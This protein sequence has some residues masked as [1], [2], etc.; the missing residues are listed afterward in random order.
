M[1]KDFILQAMGQTR[2]RLI[3]SF[4]KIVDEKL[5]DAA[6]VGVIGCQ[7]TLTEGLS[8]NDRLF[9]LRDKQLRNDVLFL[10]QKEEWDVEISQYTNSN[11]WYILIR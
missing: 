9:F 10:Y 2:K 5:C 8:K 3:E 7:V 1:K 11:E 4:K 6:R